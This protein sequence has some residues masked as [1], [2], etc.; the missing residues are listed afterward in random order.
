MSGEDA[1]CSYSVAFSSPAVSD[2][3]EAQ[4]LERAAEA[5]EPDVEDGEESPAL[6]SHFEGSFLSSILALLVL[7]AVV[8]DWFVLGRR[9]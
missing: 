7:L 9:A 1:I 8:M 2:L 3:T 4:S 5:R 6:G